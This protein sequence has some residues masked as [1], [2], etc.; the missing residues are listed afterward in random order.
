MSYRIT[1]LCKNNNCIKKN[2]MLMFKNIKIYRPYMGGIT[3]NKEE[4]LIFIVVPLVKNRKKKEKEKKG[5]RGSRNMIGN[6]N[7]NYDKCNT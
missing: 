7:K 5:Q 1:K 3:K 2:L 4:Y 6:G